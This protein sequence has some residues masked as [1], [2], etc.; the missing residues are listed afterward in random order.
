VIEAHLARIDPVNGLI[1]AVVLVMAEHALI[2]AKSMPSTGTNT[3]EWR[4]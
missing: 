1:N 2:A 4:Q 3:V